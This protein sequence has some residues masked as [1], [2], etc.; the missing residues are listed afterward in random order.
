[1][2]TNANELAA[3]EGQLVAHLITN[4]GTMVVE[5]EEH[6]APQTVANFVS[7]ANGSKS[8]D[9]PR[10]QEPGTPYYDGT[11][12]HRVIRGF[13]LQGGDPTGTGSGGPGFTFE[14]EFHPELRHDGP[15]ILSMANRGPN[16]NGSQF[17]VCQVSCP[18][19]DDRH[20]VFGRVVEGLDVID[21]IA[22]QPTG[23][24]DRPVDAVVLERVEVLRR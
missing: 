12:F 17:F 20:A 18:H 7:L 13:M 21:T 4:H 10:G 15:G 9:D 5:L 23:M 3:G 2:E 6:R 24:M 8:Y 16:T 14:D 19:L 11:V 22:D 1:M